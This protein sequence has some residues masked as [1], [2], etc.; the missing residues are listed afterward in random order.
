MSEPL[1]FGKSG[2][3]PLLSASPAVLGT[4]ERKVS[5]R[6]LWRYA[7]ACSGAWRVS[8]THRTSDLLIG[9]LFFV[10]ARERTRQQ[11]G[12]ASSDGGVTGS[13]SQRIKTGKRSEEMN[14]EWNVVKR[15]GML[16]GIAGG[17]GLLLAVAVLVLLP[18]GETEAKELARQLGPR[19]GA[20]CGWRH[21]C[22]AHHLD[23]DDFAR[24]CSAGGGS[25]NRARGRCGVQY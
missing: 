2:R 9:R 8:C 6:V 11:T 12:D 20:V 19:G 1:A 25:C 15:W 4:F 14:L 18:T 10:S 23:R 3:P 21:G 5:G 7:N 22:A 24:G 13:W 17:M 16:G